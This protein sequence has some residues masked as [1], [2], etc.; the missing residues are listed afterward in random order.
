LITRDKRKQHLGVITIHLQEDAHVATLD[1]DGHEEIAF[2]G[3]YDGH[4]G[5][6]VARFCAMHMP[7]EL[8]RRPEYKKGEVA[9]AL[10][11]TYLAID[12]LLRLKENAEL[13]NQLKVKN[14]NEA[15]S[16]YGVIEPVEQDSRSGLHQPSQCCA[17]LL[18][19]AGMNPGHEHG[20]G[21]RDGHHMI[22]LL[23][24]ALT[25]Q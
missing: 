2:F 1:F 23:P 20:I 11:A 22:A 21:D 6:Q 4:G 13:L 7:D 9:E 17:S 10:K 8:L 15:S 14:T 24:L 16:G 3:V 12:D 5:A 25:P 18:N 19:P